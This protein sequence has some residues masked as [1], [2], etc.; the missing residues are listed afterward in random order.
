MTTIRTF[1][2]LCSNRGVLR[3]LSPVAGRTATMS[4]PLLSTLLATS[5]AA[6]AAAHAG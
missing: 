5:S 2:V 1:Y 6:K 3:Y 4:L